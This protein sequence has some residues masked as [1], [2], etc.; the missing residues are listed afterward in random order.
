MIFLLECMAVVKYS[1]DKTDGGRF[2]QNDK[3]SQVAEYSDEDV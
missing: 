1:L 2:F 3:A